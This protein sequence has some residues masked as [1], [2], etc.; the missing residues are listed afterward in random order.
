MQI[1]SV[2]GSV[3]RERACRYLARRHVRTN[4]LGTVQVDDGAVVTLQF[5]LEADDL[6]DAVDVELVAEVERGGTTFNH[7]V[8]VA[9]AKA[10]LRGALL[11]SGIVKV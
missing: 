11:P 10:E 9:L 5:D 7:R 3:E 6:L 4:D 2:V 8:L 1:L